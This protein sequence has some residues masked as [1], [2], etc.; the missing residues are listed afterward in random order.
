MDPHGS[1]MTVHKSTLIFAA[2]TP[3]MRSV[4]KPVIFEWVPQAPMTE[5]HPEKA[6]GDKGNREREKTGGLGLKVVF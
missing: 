1:I 5:L 6:E 4:L 2:A 3:S